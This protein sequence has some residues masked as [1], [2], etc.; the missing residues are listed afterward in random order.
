MNR[1]NMK[2]YVRDF[3]KDNPYISTSEF[4]EAFEL[5]SLDRARDLLLDLGFRQFRN[6][7]W[8][9]PAVRIIPAVHAEQFLIPKEIFHPEPP[10][11]DKAALAGFDR[12]SS[13]QARI[14]EAVVRTEA[15]LGI[16]N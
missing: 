1:A 3:L 11:V 7:R 13:E 6:N 8:V 15:G 12:F 5:G 10:T 16:R 4:S 14:L 9:L 2:E